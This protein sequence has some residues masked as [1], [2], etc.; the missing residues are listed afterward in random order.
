MCVFQYAKVTLSPQNCVAKCVKAA[1]D[2]DGTE[3][4]G[5]DHS[6]SPNVVK[7]FAE[8]RKSLAKERNGQKRY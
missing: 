5:A 2:V 6:A 8:S 3:G 1:A 7:G 4:Q